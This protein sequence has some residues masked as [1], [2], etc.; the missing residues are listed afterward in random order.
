MNHREP[1]H[2]PTRVRKALHCLSL[3]L[4]PA[5]APASM[6]AA[7]RL[8]VHPGLPAGQQEAEPIPYLPAMGAPPL[9]FCTATPPSDL[10]ARPPAAAPPL[11]ALTRTESAVALANAAAAQSAAAHGTDKSRAG[12]NDA[13]G[14]APKRPPLPILPD[15]TRPQVRPEDFL[16]FFQVPGSAMPPGGMTPTR[17]ATLPPS[18]A[19]YIQTPQ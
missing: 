18:S 7:T 19:T 2:P 13:T 16:P 8:R 1:T 6:L 4:L 14:S 3:L 15:E 11:P 10:V 17:P 5:L 12:E 9:R